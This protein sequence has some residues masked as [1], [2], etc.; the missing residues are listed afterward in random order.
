MLLQGTNGRI[1]TNDLCKNPS[2]LELPKPGS[3]PLPSTAVQADLTA[4]VRVQTYNT[5]SGSRVNPLNEDKGECL[6]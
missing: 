6:L 5:F 1:T 4:A 2:V 3:D